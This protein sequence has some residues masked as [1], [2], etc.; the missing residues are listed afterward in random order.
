MI[1]L[2]FDT[3]NIQVDYTLYVGIL[4]GLAA[5]YLWVWSFEF[6]YVQSVHPSQEMHLYYRRP[7][8]HKVFQINSNH[9]LIWIVKYVR[10]KVIPK[11]ESDSFSFR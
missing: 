4:L 5:Q 2:L 11:E 7:L 8:L 9:L 3:T 6:R 10:K 1:D